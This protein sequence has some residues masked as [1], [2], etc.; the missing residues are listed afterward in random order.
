M[1]EALTFVSKNYN[2][3]PDI[4]MYLYRATVYMCVGSGACADAGAQGRA[5]RAPGR[6]AP[7]LALASTVSG[8][9]GG[10]H[11]PI[12]ASA[13]VMSAAARVRRCPVPL[14]SP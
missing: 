6:E 14:P 3:T 7:A 11:Q 4:H 13:A 12:T 9:D 1:I 8:H 10:G 2:G 5:E